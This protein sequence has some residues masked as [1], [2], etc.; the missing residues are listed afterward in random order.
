[1]QFWLYLGSRN[2]TPIPPLHWQAYLALLGNLHVP[3]PPGHPNFEN[4]IGDGG[5]NHTIY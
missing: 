5:V 4:N 2:S 1:M 3:H